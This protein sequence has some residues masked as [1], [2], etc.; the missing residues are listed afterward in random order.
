M[1]W[2]TGRDMID[3]LPMSPQRI[4]DSSLDVYSAILAI[5][6]VP[7]EYRILAGDGVTLWHRLTPLPRPR[8][9]SFS[10]RYVFPDYARIPDQTLAAEHGDLQAIKGTVAHLTV[11]FSEPCTEASIRF[12]GGPLSLPMK[13]T[14]ESQ[15]DFSIAI[16]IREAFRYQVTTSSKQTGLSNPSGHQFSI[17]PITDSPPVVAWSDPVEAQ[18]I[19]SAVDKVPLKIQITD[20]LPVDDVIQEYQINDGPIGSITLSV[21]TAS[22]ELELQSEFDLMILDGN[23]ESKL[24][25]GD[26]VRTRIAVRDRAGQRG[27]SL[28][29]LLFIAEDGFAPSRDQ[30]IDD[31]HDLAKRTLDW[32]QQT[33]ETLLEYSEFGL[34]QLLSE[35]ATNIDLR[36]PPEIA[37]AL[38]LLIETAESPAA[39][40]RLELT[41]RAISDLDGKIQ[42]WQTEILAAGTV[43]DKVWG[44][45]HGAMLDQLEQTPK[46]LGI[47]STN[48]ENYVRN[49]LSHRLSIHLIDDATSL[50][51]SLTSLLQAEITDERIIRHLQI[52]DGRLK[53]IDQRFA[54]HQDSLVD[55]SRQLSENWSNWRDRHSE[56]IK[57][58]VEEPFSVA[59]QRSVL[60]Q[61]ESELRSHQADKSVFNRQSSVGLIRGDK[62]LRNQIGSVTSMLAAISNDGIRSKEAEL[63]S[64][65][66][67]DSGESATWAGKA[68]FYNEAFEDKLT[69][70]LQ[71][72]EETKDLHAASPFADLPFLTDLGL[73]NSCADERHKR[74]LCRLRR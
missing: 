54:S 19:V 14:N 25:G 52:V 5:R 56:K 70:L 9:K 48:I 43:Q 4:G 61:I 24:S 74:W 51:R 42:A 45:D 72:L 22:R 6:D 68:R 2:R 71:R 28:E 37:A 47:E 59:A 57:R 73:L 27:E 41:G 34:P 18:R 15:T 53:E 50:Q 26:V 44:T 39:A 49:H 63:S 16:P 20:E 38:L 36:P 55:S 35:D 11:H 10:K 17:L 1:Q 66:A 3:E 62:A 60:E 7:I 21:P 23:D 8:I 46:R 65:D 32:T 58:A 67:N 31:L 13:P 29:L 12:I 64:K 69:L 40:E 30:R 33:R